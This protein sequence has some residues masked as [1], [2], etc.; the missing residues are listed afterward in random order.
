MLLK[1][2]TCT[3]IHLQ[4]DDVDVKVICFTCEQL[5]KNIFSISLF[6]LQVVQV[7]QAGWNTVKGPSLGATTATLQAEY[8]C[9]PGKNI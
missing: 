2:P 3:F 8:W 4:Y 7:K 9:V 6:T 5:F 1:E